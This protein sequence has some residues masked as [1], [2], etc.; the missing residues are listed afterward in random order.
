[1]YSGQ[2]I[3]PSKLYYTQKDT[4]DPRGTYINSK[5]LLLNFQSKVDTGAKELH[6]NFSA[7]Y[8]VDFCTKNDG[9]MTLPSANV[10]LP[11]LFPT[12]ITTQTI[13][14]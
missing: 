10:P 1:M 2:L 11:F 5:P 13:P 4:S 12:P 8:Y 14:S 7:S 6:G 3:S 9:V